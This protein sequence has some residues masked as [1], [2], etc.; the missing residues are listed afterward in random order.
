MDLGASSGRF[1]AGWIEDGAIRFEIVEQIPHAPIE[2]DGRS[3]WD[4]DA[5]LGLCR[6]AAD[7][8]AAHFDHATLGIDSWG[9]DHGFIDTSGQLVGPPVCYRDL[10]HAAAF[11]SLAPYR[12]ELYA[13]TGI[14]HQPFNTICQLIARREE[15]PT[16]PSRTRF[17]ILPDL[18]GYLLT[19]ETNYEL[20]EASTTQLMGLDCR[21]S[22]R[23]FEIAGWPMPEYQ[24]SKPG[25][26][27]GEVRPGV[28][29]AHVGSHDTASA[30]LGFGAQR[31]DQ[32]YVN[33][34]TWSLA[35]VIRDEPIAT[36]EAEKANFTNERMADGRVRFLKNIPGFYV[37]NR[38]HEEL[39]IIESVPE[40]LASATDVEEHVDLFAPSFFNPDSMIDACLTSVVRRPATTQEWAGLALGS[41]ARAIADQ[42]RMAVEAGAQECRFIRIGGGGSQSAALCRRIA[43]LSGL[44]VTAGPVEATVLGNLAMQFW[45]AGRFESISEME[46]AISGGGEIREYLP[47]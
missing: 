3:F 34:G 13:H 20:T 24:P 41:L 7:Y 47:A 12:E 2:R 5:L 27:G 25:G 19:G 36:P 35:M 40:W 44:P 43:S 33:V 15:D 14:Q 11:E 23:A 16:L 46:S 39:G 26:L 8:A 29:L 10:S 37:V 6:R 42:P 30:L 1:A 32:M 17:L 22:L 21:W 18:L 45:A 9:V 4:L 28:R 31:D 38:L